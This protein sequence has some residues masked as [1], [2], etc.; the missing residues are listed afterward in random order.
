MAACPRLG[1]NPPS[2]Q[3]SLASLAAA[4]SPRGSDMPP[5]CH[6]LPRGRFATLREGAKGTAA[7]GRALDERPYDVNFNRAV[8]TPH[9]LPL[10]YYLF[11]S[12]ASGGGAPTARNETWS[13]MERPTQCRNTVPAQARTILI[14]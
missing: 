5:A 4:R 2:Q 14:F 10:H 13:K 8:V 6:S 9:L 7:R 11:L 12:A 3:R 1:N